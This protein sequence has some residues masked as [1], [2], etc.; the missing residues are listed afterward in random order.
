MENAVHWED[1]QREH[2]I[3]SSWIE[4]VAAAA[5]A[6]TTSSSSIRRH[7]ERETKESFINAFN[8]Q[9]TTAFSLFKFYFISNI[10]RYVINIF[11]NILNIKIAC[12]HKN[13]FL[14]SLEF[15]NFSVSYFWISFSFYF[16]HFQFAIA[17]HFNSFNSQ[18]HTHKGN[19]I[20]ASTATARRKNKTRQHNRR[21]KMLKEFLKSIL[22]S[23]YRARIHN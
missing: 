12:R 11:T 1:Y 19:Y 8:T 5:A 21:H 20:I 6:T 13:I 16:F 14:C 4:A 9:L 15:H 10:R 23:T 22:N 7:V 18:T 17:S 2:C 3:A